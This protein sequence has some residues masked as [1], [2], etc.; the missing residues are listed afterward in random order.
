MVWSQQG[1]PF[2]AIDLLKVSIEF[3]T[4]Y[5]IHPNSSMLLT[6]GFLH[7]VSSVKKTDM[8]TYF[9]CIWWCPL[10][11]KFWKRVAGELGKIFNNNIN[12]EPGLFLLNIV[13][14]G[15]FMPYTQENLSFKLLLLARRC[16]LFQWIKPRPPTVNQWLGEI[17]KVIPMEWLSVGLN[18]NESSFDRLWQPFL[19]YVPISIMVII[20]RGHH[21]LVWSPPG[22]P[23]SRQDCKRLSLF[24]F[25]FDFIFFFHFDLH[26]RISCLSVLT[27]DMIY[28]YGTVC[29]HVFFGFIIFVL[30]CFF[31]FEKLNKILK[32]KL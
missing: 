23:Q 9:H 4:G 28:Q 15:L 14:E 5:S 19:D 2:F 30:C 32:I 3:F 7:Y 18:G 27:H 8:R 31:I 12:M 11:S 29:C 13:N 10:I 24:V 22:G 21:A 17:F 6:Q 26:S 1:K 20:Q 25:I 16:V